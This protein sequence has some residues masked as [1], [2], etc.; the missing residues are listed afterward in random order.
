MDTEKLLHHRMLKFRN[1][2]GFIEGQPI[3]PVKKINMKRK[4]EPI[5]DV[6][7]LAV[8]STLDLEK[9]V[10]KLK[11]QIIKS[12]ENSSSEPIDVGVSE[13]VVKLKKDVDQELTEAAEF[14]GLTD[15]LDM[16]RSEITKARGSL[17][18]PMDSSLKDKIEKLKQEFQQ[19]LANYP[20]SGSLNQKLDMLKDLSKAQKIV[21]L[22]Q[23]IKEGLKVIMNRPDLK[24]KVDMLKEEISNTG[25][26]KT[27]DLDDD[28]K[29][30]ILKV[31]K[32]IASELTKTLKA[33]NLDVEPVASKPIFAELKEKADE[34]NSEVKERIQEAINSSDLKSKIET[35]KLEVEKAGKSLDPQSKRKILLM[36][37][38]IK[39]SLAE[40]VD[41]PKLKEKY[42]TLK[43]EF[44]TVYSENA[45]EEGSSGLN[46]GLNHSVCIDIE[47]EVS[48]ANI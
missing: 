37:E 44:N 7:K 17:E 39:H 26:S 21:P 27:S 4:D 23:K 2:G 9:E 25:V 8:A 18:Q 3:D 12:K 14:M 28:L 5:I 42:E 40:A 6:E 30:K 11:D 24:M 22:K 46:G 31:K 16:L 41:S 1:L 13:L 45:S 48:K 38:E 47:S 19:G 36:K 20:N 15:K 10:E 33:E 32:D 43:N 29:E 34:L 35:L